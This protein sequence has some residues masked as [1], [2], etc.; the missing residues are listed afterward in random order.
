MAEIIGEITQRGYLYYDW[1][2][3]SGDDTDVVY[4]AETL[5]QNMLSGVKDHSSVVFLCHD[6]STPKTTAEAVRLVIRKLRD[7]GWHFARLTPA[8][9]A[10]HIK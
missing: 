2:V 7:E 4:P 1:D 8:V 3:V 10:V 6:N 9:E 5:A